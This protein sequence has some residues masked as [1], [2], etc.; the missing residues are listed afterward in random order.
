MLNPRLAPNQ[1]VLNSSLMPFL[2]MKRHNNILLMTQI[3]RIK[4]KVCFLLKLNFW[5]QPDMQVGAFVGC[6][7]VQTAAAGWLSERDLETARV[8]A[9]FA[10]C[11]YQLT[12]RPACCLREAWCRALSNHSTDVCGIDA[13]RL[14]LNRGW[15]ATECNLRLWLREALLRC[16]CR[17]RC[18]PRGS[19]RIALGGLWGRSLEQISTPSGS[20]RCRNQQQQQQQQRDMQVEDFERALPSLPQQLQH[21][22]QLEG[23]RCCSTPSISAIVAACAAAVCG[24]SSGSLLLLSTLQSRCSFEAKFFALQQLLQV[25]PEQQQHARQDVRDLLFR[26]MRLRVCSEAA[27]ACSSSSSSS[28]NEETGSAAAALAAAAADPAASSEAAAVHNKV[29]LLAARLLAADLQ[30]LAAAVGTPAV[31]AAAAAH[32]KAF[33]PLRQLVHE[34]VCA[35]SLHL[36][37]A[38]ATSAALAATAIAQRCSSCCSSTCAAAAG[39]S[40]PATLES[41]RVSLRVLLMLHQEYLDDMPASPL[42]AALKSSF[43]YDE[44]PS[45]LAGAIACPPPFSPLLLQLLQLLQQTH[46]HSTALGSVLQLCCSVAERYVG[47]IDLLL[48]LGAANGAAAESGTK[49]SKSS[50]S[51]NM[52]LLQLLGSTWLS[53]GFGDAAS[54]IVV[55][56]HRKM[57]PVAR[58]D[59]LC[60]MDVVE[61]LLHKIPLGEIASSPALLSPFAAIVNAAAAALIEACAALAEKLEAAGDVASCEAIA[62]DGG[63]SSPQVAGLNP[64]ELL[65]QGLSAIWMLLPLSIQLLG[66]GGLAVSSAVVNSLS[67]LLSKALLLQRQESLLLQPLQAS[68]FEL[69]LVQL[70]QVLLKRLAEADAL[71]EAAQEQQQQQEQHQHVVYTSLDEE[72]MEQLYAY[73]EA[74]TAL[75]RRACASYQ[76]RVLLW[77]R[78]GLQQQAQQQQQQQPQQRRAEQQALSALLHMLLILTDDINDL[79]ERLKDTSSPLHAC[80]LQ[81]LQLLQSV[82]ASAAFSSATAAENFMRVLVRVSP[83]FIKQQQYIPEALSLLAGPHGVCSSNSSTA[84]KACLALLRFVKNCLPHSAAYTGLLLQHLLQQQCLDVPSS[85]SNSSNK[86]AQRRMRPATPPSCGNSSRQEPLALAAAADVYVYPRAFQVEQQLLLYEASGVLLGSRVQQQQQQQQQ[87][88]GSVAFEA[89]TNGSSCAAAGAKERLLLLHA[90]LSKATAAFS[91]EMPVHTAAE[92]GA[93]AA[94]RIVIYWARSTN[95]LASL[96]K[97]FQPFKLPTAAGALSSAPRES[98]AELSTAPDTHSA[99]MQTL[100]VFSDAV[101]AAGKEGSAL[102][103]GGTNLLLMPPFFPACIFLLRRLLCLLGPLAAPAIGGLLPLLYD[104]LLLEADS[105]GPVATGYLELQQQPVEAAAQQLSGFCSQVIVSLR[106]PELMGLLLQHF[107]MMLDRNLGLYL[108]AVA[109]EA[110]QPASAELQRECG[111]LHEQMATLV[112]VAAREAPEALL[113]FAAAS[114]LQEGADCSNSSSSS[115]SSGGMALF[116]DAVNQCL[117]D[118]AA[119][120]SSNSNS[121]GGMTAQRALLQL[122]HRHEQ[123]LHALLY[124]TLQPSRGSSAVTSR[125]SFGSPASLEIGSITWRCIVLLLMQSCCPPVGSCVVAAAAAISAQALGHLAVAFICKGSRLVDGEQQQEQHQQQERLQQQQQ[126]LAVLPQDLQLVRDSLRD[127]TQ[128]NAA[129]HLQLRQRRSQSG[130][131]QSSPPSEGV[132]Q[133]QQ[134]QQQRAQQINQ[135]QAAQQLSLLLPLPPLFLISARLFASLRPNDP[136][137]LKVAADIGGLWRVLGFGVPPGTPQRS[138]TAAATAA[139][140]AAGARL[141]DFFSP[142]RSG[143]QQALAEALAPLVADAPHAAAALVEAL[144][145]AE[146]QQLRDV[147]RGWQQRFLSKC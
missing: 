84:P 27:W 16:T 17:L 80:L 141:P 88:V 127:F 61:W 7:G 33:L 47:W 137:H 26:R 22:L 28:V 89:S 119:V 13:G 128:Q 4:Q 131:P 59:L 135:Q 55:L 29:A 110:Q 20:F 2:L 126:Q 143:I 125:A 58:I 3:E 138:A 70:L 43:P 87:H 42:S 104:A 72:E 99:W 30:D 123:Q 75:F 35:L 124:G 53:S 103:V 74:L 136:Q 147:V 10:T 40:L 112:A 96:S 9:F 81:L 48:P 109:A 120:S 52:N 62:A 67:L 95:A 24:S 25:L 97:G 94:A 38:G 5:L 77:I 145:R 91:S 102:E 108:K 65:Q 142:L 122:L 144:G 129:F 132:Q 36:Q 63:S 15:A 130:A 11:G 18:G 51:S 1:Y 45:C 134:L 117:A 37:Q 73:K 46:K 118:A 12:E 49:D 23:I 85:S 41:L 50:S 8:T 14:L 6:R 64:R 39:Q 111:V 86:V 34:E 115:D 79:P 31:A 68:R 107:P 44:D 32:T 140:A 113:T 114:V 105:L 60:R 57:E 100:A 76:T 93:A 83:L 146:G 69:L 92:G 82:H 71:A 19:R 66:S 78:E 56:L 101:L 21:L 106:G 98:S 133:L 90:L 116:A 121:S 54:A 139:A